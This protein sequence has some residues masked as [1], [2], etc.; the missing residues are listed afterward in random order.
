[1]QIITQNVNLNQIDFVSGGER[2]DWVFSNIIAYIKKPHI[3][4][5]NDLNVFVSSKDF[6]ITEKVQSLGG[7]KCLHISDLII[8]AASYINFWLPAIEQLEGQLKWTATIVDNA[9]WNR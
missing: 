6:N 2:S 9:R 1:M 7:K 4:I 3:T 8:E 5:F